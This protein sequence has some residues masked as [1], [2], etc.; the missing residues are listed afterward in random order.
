MIINRK[1]FLDLQMEHREHILAELFEAE[2][3]SFKIKNI[4]VDLGIGTGYN[5]RIAVMLSCELSDEIVK[6]IFVLEQ[7]SND[8]LQSLDINEL[9]EYAVKLK[10]TGIFHPERDELWVL[11]SDIHSTEMFKH[12][13][14]KLIV[15]DTAKILQKAE[16]H[17]DTKRELRDVLRHYGFVKE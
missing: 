15:T 16:E 4:G 17:Y 10:E 1:Q 2:H 8:F 3:R 13:H 11:S 9:S 5:V 14:G 6:K 7:E 12:E